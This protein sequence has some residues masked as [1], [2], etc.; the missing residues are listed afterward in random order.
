[1]SLSVKHVFMLILSAAFAAATGIATSAFVADRIFL[2][3]VASVVSTLALGFEILVTFFMK[4]HEERELALLREIRLQDL[5]RQ[6]T[7]TDEID[8]RIRQ[9]IRSGDL[10]R[11]RAWHE[12][13]RRLRDE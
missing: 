8:A 10:E 2:T 6:I 12:F 9:E 7:L 11:A 13:R 1:M 3:I 5:A 4:S